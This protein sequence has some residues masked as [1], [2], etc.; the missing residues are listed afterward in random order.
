M[1]PLCRDGL[2][3]QRRLR[4]GRHGDVEHLDVRV[5]E[6]LVDGGVDARD[7]VLL[8][9]GLGAGRGCARRWRRG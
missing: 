7:A 1:W 6:Q 5:G 9:D 8:G 2:A 3:D 4:V